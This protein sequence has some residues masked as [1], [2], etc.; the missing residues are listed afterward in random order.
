MRRCVPQRKRGDRLTPVDCPTLRDAPL[1][2][3]PAAPWVRARASRAGWPDLRRARRAFSTVWQTGPGQAARAVKF[4]F[5]HSRLQ[6][7]NEGT[8]DVDRWDL[9]GTFRFHYRSRFGP[10]A[11]SHQTPDNATPLKVAHFTMEIPANSCMEFNVHRALE[12][13]LVFVRTR[14]HR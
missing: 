8:P 12:Y 2:G 9:L 4:G 11:L 1:R 3:S 10:R 7:F 6:Y 5:A 13:R 14:S